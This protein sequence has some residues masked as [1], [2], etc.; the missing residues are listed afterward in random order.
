M[1]EMGKSTKLCDVPQI[2]T[3]GIC[4]AI[5]QHSLRVDDTQTSNHRNIEINNVIRFCTWM[6]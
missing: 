3:D 4:D 5:K 2:S 1:T 6:E